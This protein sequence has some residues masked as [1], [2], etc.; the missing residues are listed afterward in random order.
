MAEQL[1]L[2]NPRRRRRVGRP[3][4][5]TTTR[6]RRRRNPRQSYVSGSAPVR[7]NPRRRS[8]RKRTYKRRYRRNPRALTVANIFQETVMPAV[9]AAGGALG[10]DILW[11]MLPIP[12]T[13]K[14]GPV[15][16]L[17]KGAGAIAMG[18]AASFMVS[19]QVAKHFTSGAMTV[20]MYDML[21]EVVATWMPQLALAAYDIEEGLMAYPGAGLDVGDEAQLSHGYN[22]ESGMSAYF[23]NDME[24]LGAYLTEDE[25]EVFI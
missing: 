5:R 19:N 23:D 16:Y 22:N 13:M 9:T 21:K 15:R 1:L 2:V 10:L 24:G 7:R 6:K 17:A 20:V 8:P 11:G 3:R 4:K 25:A 12:I 14:T 18:W